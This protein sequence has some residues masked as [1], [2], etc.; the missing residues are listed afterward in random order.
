MK[1]KLVSC[2]KEAH[3]NASTLKAFNQSI[4]TITSTPDLQAKRKMSHSIMAEKS[5]NLFFEGL[6]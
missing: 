1:G 5:T 6:S 3:G 4:I 2:P